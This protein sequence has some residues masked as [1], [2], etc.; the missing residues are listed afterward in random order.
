MQGVQQID[1][2]ML[3]KDKISLSE[4]ILLYEAIPNRI[5]TFTEKTKKK[6]IWYDHVSRQ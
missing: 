5:E 3:I 6:E 1:R 4:L 2:E